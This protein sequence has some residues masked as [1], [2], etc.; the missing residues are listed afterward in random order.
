MSTEGA[1][2][3]PEAA[4]CAAI[5][6]AGPRGNNDAAWIGKIND[7]LPRIVSMLGEGSRQWRIAEEVANATVFTAIYRGYRVEESSTRC[8]V[9]IET[10]PTKKRPDGIEEIRSHRTDGGQG[11]SMQRAL[12]QLEPGDNVVVW[13]AIETSANDAD[14]KVRVLVNIEKRPKFN[15]NAQ[16]SPSVPA[17]PAGRGDEV[18]VGSPPGAPAEAP[19]GDSIDSERL[20]AWRAGVVKMLTADELGDLDFRLKGQGYDFGGVSEVEW[21]DIVRPMVRELLDTRKT[22]QG[23]NQ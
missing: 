16:Q 22:N 5:A 20:E 9:T 13:K 11:R 12:D 21:G 17:E 6:A 2:V 1:G 10:S 14:L 18:D 23:G 7:A 15:K 4:I 19:L 8:V 3:K